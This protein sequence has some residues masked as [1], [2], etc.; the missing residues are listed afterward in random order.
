M[1]RRWVTRPLD[2]VNVAP[3][4]A[5][6][7]RTLTDSGKPVGRPSLPDMALMLGVPLIAGLVVAAAGLQAHGIAVLASAVSIFAVLMFSLLVLA[8]NMMLE[9]SSSARE[10]GASD[11]TR[12]RAW[13]AGQFGANVA[14]A[15]LVSILTAAV[16]VG[17]AMTVDPDDNGVQLLNP[18][19]TGV[20]TT[21]LAHLGLTLLMVL[22]RV[23]MI[24]RGEAVVAR[25]ASETAGHS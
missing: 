6:H 11:A 19:A 12:R 2:K 18:L 13:V 15:V 25:T 7:Y 10:A 20:V 17:L 3:L 1:T 23:A 22:K 24:L 14:Y 4:I 16:V 9:A 5:D 8:L 21:L